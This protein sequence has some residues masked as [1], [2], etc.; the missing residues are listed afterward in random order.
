MH[1]RVENLSEKAAREIL[2][3][4]IIMLDELDGDDFFGTQGW[5]YYLNMEDEI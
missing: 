2:S 3:K 5:R 4:L 1:K